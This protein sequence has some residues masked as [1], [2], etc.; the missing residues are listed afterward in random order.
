VTGD[1]PVLAAQGRATDEAA[2][3]DKL[4]RLGDTPFALG[5]SRT[6]NCRRRGDDRAGRDEP[7]AARARESCSPTRRGP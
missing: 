6:T 5:S 3:R 2:L 1:A 4:G 7:G